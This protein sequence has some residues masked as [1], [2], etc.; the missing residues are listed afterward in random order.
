MSEDFFS[1]KPKDWGSISMQVRDW[2]SEKDEKARMLIPGRSSWF[3]QSSPH[4]S[5]L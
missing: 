2:R 3:Q 4:G 5:P 1:T